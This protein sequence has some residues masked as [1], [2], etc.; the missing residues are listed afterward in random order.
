MSAQPG[1]IGANGGNSNYGLSL[2]MNE[3]TANWPLI[4]YLMDDPIYLQLYKNQLSSFNNTY[5]GTSNMQLLIDKYFDLITDAV[6]GIEG[7]QPH[8]TLLNSAAAFLNERANLK[9]H[10]NSRDQLIRSYAP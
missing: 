8:Y 6:C 2:S 9:N 7:E 4:R 3:V 5:F 10:F 1:I